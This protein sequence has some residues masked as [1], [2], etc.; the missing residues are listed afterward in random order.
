MDYFWI[1]LIIFSGACLQGITG[2]GSGLVAVPLLSLLLPLSVITPLLSVI[3]LT[4]AIYLGWVLRRYISI[5]KWQPLLVTGVIGT[6]AGNYVLA[7]Y[8]L[9]LLQQAM[10][11]AVIL[12]AAIFWSGFQF[13]TR[14]TPAQQGFTGLL[15]GFGNGAL[16]L[17]GPPVVL[18]LTSHRLDRL[19]FRATLA[20]FFL[21]LAVTN[22]TS[23]AVRGIYQPEL[24]PILLVLLGGALSGAWLGHYL[25]PKL[26]ENLFRKLTLGLVMVAGVVAL[27]T[28]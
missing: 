14:G 24:L 20:L 1:F 18:F 9:A 12:V 10:A 25:S 11:V 21:V 3:N 22:V 2:F 8:D 17:G 4:L 16:T 6:L 19:S 26:S 28:S 15:A 7:F 13:Q 23:F 5:S 27:I